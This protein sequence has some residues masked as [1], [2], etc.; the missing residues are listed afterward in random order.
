VKI[1]VVVM[2]LMYSAL[3]VCARVDVQVHSLG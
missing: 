3:D 1:A 2:S